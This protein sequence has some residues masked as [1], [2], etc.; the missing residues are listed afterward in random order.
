MSSPGT[1]RAGAAEPERKLSRHGAQRFHRLDRQAGFERA[2]THHRQRVL[3]CQRENVFA[4]AFQAHRPDLLFPERVQLFDDDERLDL[5]SKIADHFFGDGMA[6]AQLQEAVAFKDLARVLIGHAA[7]D[8]ADL[9]IAP[10]DAVERRR[11]GVRFELE[12]ALLDDGMA[13]PGVRRDDDV[14]LGIAIE[15]SQRRERAALLGHVHLD[16]GLAMAEPRRRAEHHD[17]VEL[18][19]DIKSKRCPIPGFL[20]VGRLDA[21]DLGKS[22]VLAIV[23]LVLR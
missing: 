20:A 9:F 2:L 10:L 23:L 3:A 19:R 16:G 8:D 1:A 21:R 13:Q 22:C 6:E 18:L 14:F 12:D 15:L 5:C 4:V 7:R 17:R 11:L